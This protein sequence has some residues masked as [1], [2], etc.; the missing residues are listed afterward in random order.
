MKE[1]VVMKKEYKKPI[2][3]ENVQSMVCYQ[4]N[5]GACNGK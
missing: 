2:I 1:G 4:C 3:P 5:Q